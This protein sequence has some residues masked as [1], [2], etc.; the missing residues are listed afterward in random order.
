M[1]AYQAGLH[2]FNAR[3]NVER[4]VPCMPRS[5]PLPHQALRKAPQLMSQDAH[6]QD[7]A[8]T[9]I[10]RTRHRMHKRV[11]PVH[12]C[13][14]NWHPTGILDEALTM[15]WEGVLPGAA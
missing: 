3:H 7:G 8:P 13:R 9:P 14:F 4:V 2:V 15:V 11:H 10:C 5:G 12:A 6:I 1:S